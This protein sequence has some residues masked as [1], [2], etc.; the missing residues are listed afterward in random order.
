MTLYIP[1][2]STA[3]PQLLEQGVDP[4]DI[5]RVLIQV[6]QKFTP[7]LQKASPV[8]TGRLRRSL[9]VELLLDDM[10][11]ALT[12]PVFYA[13]FVEFGTRKMR[14]KMYAI[15]LVPSIYQYMNELLSQLGT[16]EPAKSIQKITPGERSGQ[17]SQSVSQGVLSAIQGVRVGSQVLQPFTVPN[18]AV[19]SLSVESATVLGSAITLETI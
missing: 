14:P 1:I 19:E 4:L 18:V 15:K 16:F 9:R 3:I 13:G 12:S 2:I 5:R 17:V 8:D 7:I 11:V 6:A 10:G